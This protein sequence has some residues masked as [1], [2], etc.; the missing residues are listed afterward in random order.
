MKIR[1]PQLAILSVV[2]IFG[3]ILISMLA[4]LWQS[5]S[6][7]I[8]AAY[9]SGEYAGEYN[10]ADIRGSYSFGDIASAFDVPAEVLIEAFGFDGYDRPAAMQVKLFEEIYG[11]IDGL[12]VGT[13]SMRLFVALYLSRPYTPEEGTG[14]PARAVELLL[15]EE[16]IGQE[17]AAELKA[18][19]VVDISGK[20]PESAEAAVQAAEEAEEEESD[21]TIKG[22]TTFRDLVEWGLSRE[23]IE[24]VIGMPPGEPTQAMRDFFMEQGVEFSTVKDELQR[25]VDEKN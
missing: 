11:E 15:Q 22:N 1:S 25:R 16:K 8:P 10:P 3:G 24:E 18:G 19:M 9:T 20:I 4:G 21:T 5:E 12:E 2:F 23:E 6:S 17:K 13:D 7:K 14:L